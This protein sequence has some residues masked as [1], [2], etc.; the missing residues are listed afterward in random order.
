[1][2]GADKPR[3]SELRDWLPVVPSFTGVLW[4]RGFF[5]KAND[6][7][8]SGSVKFQVDV[9]AGFNAELAQPPFWWQQRQGVPS[10]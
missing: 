3:F 10:E 4:R 6:D 2:V 7:P 1:L 8:F 9:I 5:F